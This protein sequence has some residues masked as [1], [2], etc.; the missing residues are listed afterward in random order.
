MVREETVC[1]FANI[2]KEYSSNTF[3][4]FSFLPYYTNRFAVCVC[5]RIEVK[6][7]EKPLS[8][9]HGLKPNFG[10]SFVL[11]A[12]GLATILNMLASGNNP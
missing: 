3:R 8:V 11:L 12:F 6:S 5:K 9:E 7:R 1:L 4:S 10:N 2:D